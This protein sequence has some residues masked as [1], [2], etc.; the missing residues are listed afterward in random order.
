M[1]TSD[2]QLT[3]KQLREARL[4]GSTPIVTPEEAEASRQADAAVH[5]APAAPVVETVPEPEPESAD[6]PLTRRQVREQ[7][8]IR[9]ASVPVLDE[10]PQSP[11]LAPVGSPPILPAPVASAPAA[12]PTAPPRP[13]RAETTGT[14]SMITDVPRPSFLSR[15]RAPEPSPAAPVGADEQDGVDDAEQGVAPVSASAL[16]R[17]EEDAGRAHSVQD[18]KPEP[19][20]PMVESIAAPVAPVLPA[21]SK[22]SAPTGPTPLEAL[23]QQAD[24]PRPQADAPRPQAEAPRPLTGES[25]VNPGF[26][27]RVLAD[28]AVDPAPG[29]FDQLLVSDSTGS[30]HAAPN[31]LI[32]Q[33]A[34]AGLSLS[35]PVASTGEV[36]VTGSYDLPAGLGSRGHAD[37]VADGKEIDA[38]LVDGELAPASSPTP[39]AA[40]AAIGTIKPAGEVIRPP[41]P[42][43]GN[44]LMLALTITAGALA[45]ALVGALIVAITTGAFS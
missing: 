17:A 7:E 39:I 32:F 6:E 21:S 2:Q 31:A 33:Q 9:T 19:P 41:E 14:P 27:Q 3:R 38:I 25:T 16:M 18:A 24:A 30:H 8:R 20:A 29:S 22:P 5:V 13:D 11:A 35:G 44:K 23:L 26:G 43:K 36:L 45:V 4:T 40:S 34:P 15:R 42:E 28:Q 12:A 10:T 1:S 37:G